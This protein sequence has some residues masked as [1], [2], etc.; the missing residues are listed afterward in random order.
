MDAINYV[1][2][3]CS[4]IFMR[5]WEVRIHN[6]NSHFQLS[7]IVRLVNYIIGGING[8][9]LPS[10]ASF[11]RLKNRTGSTHE[12]VGMKAD[13]VLRAALTRQIG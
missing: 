10:D 12:P 5:R 2:T 7:E 3:I 4:Q 11:Y 6:D 1:C 9:Y 13:L 8:K